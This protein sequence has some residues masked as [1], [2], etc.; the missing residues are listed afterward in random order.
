MAR[1]SSVIAANSIKAELVSIPRLRGFVLNAV[2]DTSKDMKKRLEQVVATWEEPVTFS[3]PMIR[4]AGG[5]AFV[6]I[7]T[8]ND[9]FRYLDEGTDERWAI[10]NKPYVPKTRP[11]GG[12]KS[13]TGTRTYNKHGYYT[14]IVGRR[15]MQAKGIPPM[16]GIEARNWTINLG[17]D[18]TSALQF[19]MRRA[20]EDGTP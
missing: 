11:G 9:I 4:Y 17:R 6:R 18:A 12:Y 8:D 2:L 13:G 7:S 1:V 14:A 20:I 19:R 16:P 10:M 15:A 3:R 5:N